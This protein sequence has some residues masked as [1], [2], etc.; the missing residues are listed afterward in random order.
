MTGS[1]GGR[2]ADKNIQRGCCVFGVR[3]CNTK[4]GGGDKV[5]GPFWS[6]Q[7]FILS[8]EAGIVG[9]LLGGAFLR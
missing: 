7:G 8:K 9:T 4:E 3:V 6:A 5:E 1:S 2:I